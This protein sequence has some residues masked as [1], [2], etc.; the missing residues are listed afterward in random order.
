MS[1]IA[2]LDDGLTEAADS[3]AGVA[4]A[5]IT[6]QRPRAYTPRSWGRRRSYTPP[7]AWRRDLRRVAPKSDRYSW[8]ELVWVAGDPWSPIQRW[9]LYQMVPRRLTPPW[10]AEWLDGPN[11]RTMGYWSTK[12]GEWISKAPPI[13]ELQWRLW[14][15]HNAYGSLWWVIQGDAGGHRHQLTDFEA[16]LVK[17]RGY[18]GPWP[19]PGDLPYAHYD[20]RVADR[21]A[22][23]DKMQSYR[24]MAEFAER[25]PDQ[26][27][28]EEH[29][30]AAH[31]RQQLGRWLHGQIED[32]VGSVPLIAP[33]DLP[34][35]APGFMADEDAVDHE[36][37]HD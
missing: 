28:S 37:I 26:L 30:V 7:D 21:V 29:D 2:R 23:F 25:N 11:P 32:A 4:F 3:L 20:H 1:R 18:T 9:C 14:R 19:E 17:I 6:G 34:T 16:K 35:A 15:E 10:I 12:K 31:M 5:T 13:S 22:A 24:M 36:F 33:S 8:L 27:D